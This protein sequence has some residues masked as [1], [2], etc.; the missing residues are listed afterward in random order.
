MATRFHSLCNVTPN[1]W[2]WVLSWVVSSSLLSCNVELTSKVKADLF[3]STTNEIC[4][5]FETF[6]DLRHLISNGW[7]SF[8]KLKGKFFCFWK[9]A[10]EPF[11]PLSCFWVWDE[12]FFFIWVDAQLNSTQN[13]NSDVSDYPWCTVF[14]R[15]RLDNPSLQEQYTQT[16]A[17][18]SLYNTMHGARMFTDPPPEVTLC[19]MW[20]VTST[21][22]PSCVQ[23]LQTKNLLSVRHT[24]LH[25]PDSLSLSLALFHTHTLFFPQRICGNQVGILVND[26]T[27]KNTVAL[28]Q[29]TYTHT[30]RHTHTHTNT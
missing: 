28:G 5:E 29:I 19:D 24:S 21:A 9:I 15:S 22:G 23:F 4:C 7:W 3:P 20:H 10:Q 25:T 1:I 30:H 17:S 26:W 2:V 12:L 16:V 13:S 18:G 8:V 27:C 6:E 11:V 14:I